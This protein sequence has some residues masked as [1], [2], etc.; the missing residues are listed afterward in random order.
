MA[1][2]ARPPR[3]P[4]RTY[5]PLAPIGPK[6]LRRQVTQ[7]VRA[8]TVPLARELTRQINAA[9][10]AGA[11]NISGVSNQLALNLGSQQGIQRE[12][13]ERARG[14]LGAVNTE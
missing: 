12:I 4:G 5:D 10:A 6:Q 3:P 11:A 2:A 1:R 13:Y 7:D 14:N 9:A 8:Q